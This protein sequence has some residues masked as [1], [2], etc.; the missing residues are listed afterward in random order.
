MSGVTDCYQPAERHFKLTRQCLEVLRE[1]RNPV[2]V[3]TK[4]ALVTRDIDLL[5]DLAAVG[6]AR[7]MISVT[8]LNSELGR[9]MEPRASSP[10]MRLDAIRQLSASGIP[11]GVM[12]APMIPGLTDHEMPAILEAAR[13][14]GATSAGYILL[15]L[16]HGVKELFCTWLEKNEPL[17][18]ERVI[19]RVRRSREGKLYTSRWGERLRGSGPFADQ[20]ANV[21][22]VWTRR[23]K[24]ETGPRNL[25]VTAFTRKE[26]TQL[27]I[28]I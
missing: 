8:T 7:V 13:D 27:E 24:Y 18:K 10:K 22:A 11:V 15:R 23:L 12:A 25:S 3:I 21:F 5:A 9:K 19:D 20:L 26:E 16:P 28:P 4:N 14:S 2:S 17:K 6:A 1:F